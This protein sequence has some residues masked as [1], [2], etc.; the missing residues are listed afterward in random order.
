MKKGV[1]KNILERLHVLRGIIEKH[2]H[3]YHSLDR[4]EITD[5]AYDS[6]LKELVSIEEK[7]PELKDENSPSERVGGEPSK[8]FNKVVH[9][10]KQWSFDDVFDFEELIKWNE[11]V[12]NF[13]RKGGIENEE[14]KYN[15]ELKIDGLKV[16][17]TYKDGRLILGSTRGDG[18]IGEDVTS[19]IKTIKSIPLTLSKKIDIVVVGEAWMSKKTLEKINSIRKETGESPYANTRNLAA[20]SLRQLDSKVTSSRELDSFFY[21]IDLLDNNMPETQSGELKLLKDLNLKVNTHSKLLYDIEEIEEYY[22]EWSKKKDTLD[23]ELDGIVIKIDS[24]KIQQTLGYT[25][26]SPRFG[27]A[28]KF[29]AMQVRNLDHVLEDQDVVEIHVR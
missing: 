19:N 14:I 4:P 29:P 24:R 7:Y 8:E 11:K 23:Y 22:K 17:L 26:K 10:T 3:L 13:M 2:R 15:C 27:I 21:D 18:E 5:E 6:L 12:K 16:I 1:P 20:G 9:K 25:G 28:Y